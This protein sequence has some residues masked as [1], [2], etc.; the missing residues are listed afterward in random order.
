MSAI[1]R[2]HSRVLDAL[3]E[4]RVTLHSGDMGNTF[5]LLRE[6]AMPWKGGLERPE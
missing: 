1:R 5:S 4:R 3:P 6:R 2:R